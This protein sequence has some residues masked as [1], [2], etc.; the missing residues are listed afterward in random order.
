[1]AVPMAF[2]SRRR[3]AAPLAVALAAAAAVTLSGCTQATAGS[4]VAAEPGPLPPVEIS[5]LHLDGI[6]LS[7]SELESATGLS[8][9]HVVRGQVTKMWDDS[10]GMD[11]PQ[12][13]GAVFPL[14]I[15]SYGGAEWNVVRG[16]MLNDAPSPTERSEHSVIQGVVRF[17]DSDAARAYSQQAAAEWAD[18]DGALITTTSSSGRST[19]WALEEFVKNDET[20]TLTQSPVGT[21]NASCLRALRA[22]S[23]VVIDVMVCGS[24]LTDEAAAV[25][26]AIADGM[27]QL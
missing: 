10:A 27:P 11:T 1:M 16:S 26:G 20:L 19:V 23:N 6:L 17:A 3:C 7:T 5:I 22:H 13:V 9:L 21:A 18:C 2:T 8:S 12:C 25:T 14:Q 4:P 24:D 15:R